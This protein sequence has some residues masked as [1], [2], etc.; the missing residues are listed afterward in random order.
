MDLEIAQSNCGASLNWRISN[1]LERHR[2]V[3]SREWCHM[4]FRIIAESALI[5]G[6]ARILRSLSR[7][8]KVTRGDLM[9]KE[10]SSKPYRCFV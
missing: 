1:C 8:P 7:T 2:K 9:F 6:T 5:L 4:P 3:V 10:D